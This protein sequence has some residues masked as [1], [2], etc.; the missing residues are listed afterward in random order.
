[1]PCLSRPVLAWLRPI[2]EVRLSIHLCRNYMLI[3][4]MTGMT[5]HSWGAVSP[6]VTKI[7]LQIPC[8]KTCKPAFQRWKKTKVL[9][10][11][12]GVA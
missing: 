12:E 7:E 2:L 9:I 11:D 10:I 1:M 6:T 3:R 4:S 5:I 8:I